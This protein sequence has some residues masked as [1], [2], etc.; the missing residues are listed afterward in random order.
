MMAFAGTQKTTMAILDE[1]FEGSFPPSGW[2]KF[3][4]FSLES[5]Q[6][7]SE[8]S[9]TGTYSAMVEV[10]YLYNQD[11]WL[12]TPALDLSGVSR[13][14]L[15]FYEDQNGWEGSS[16]TNSIEVSTTSNNS[17]S[18]FT[19]I[20]TMTPSDHTI[21]GFDGSVV[22]V[23]LSAYAGQ[24]TVYIA[25]HYHDPSSPNYQWY[26]DDVR[27]VTPSDHD[28]AAI[29]LDMDEHYAPNTTVT[30]QATV[31]NEGKNTESFDVEFGYY[32][33]YGEE[34]AISSTTVTDLAPGAETQI[35][36]SSYTFGQV[37]YKFYV[38]T[39]LSGDMDTAND[40]ATR[41]INS[42]PNQKEVVLSEEFTDTECT[43][44]PGAAEA[45][46]SLYQTYPDNVAIIAY[47]GGFS[48]N[49]PFN[50]EFALA[51]RHYYDVHSYPTC[52]FGG[53]RRKVG[54]AA[55]GSDWSGVYAGYEDAYLAERQEYTPLSLDIVWTENG[56]NTIN[57]TGT[58]TYD[59][60]I[61]IKNLYIRWA[62]CESHIA[63]NW[64]TSMD[65]LHFVER[66]MIPDSVG[67]KVWNNDYPA[68]V[69]TE[70]DNSISFDIPEGVVKENCELIAFVQNDDDK[71]ILVAAKVNLGDGPNAISG[72]GTLT[73]GQFALEQNYPNPF[74]PTTTIRYALPKAAH[75][76]LTLYDITGRKIATLIN[77]NKTAGH[78]EYSLNGSRLAS[79]IYFYSLDAGNFHATRKMI[80]LR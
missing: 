17:A 19:P 64:E 20:L 75:V 39:K 23:D 41:F 69:G 3:S 45:L 62:L 37:G 61:T 46:D 48:G 21:E 49:D 79:G 32:D 65:S 11:V 24:S 1:S 6:Q 66:L 54:G 40:V 15:Y 28:V 29:S 25:F 7:S 42:Y 4:S 56:S 8:K 53:D 14:T 18:A 52:I 77:E 58:V 9:R 59:A 47:H 35:S 63:Y 26:I 76:T 51:R 55:A 22:E 73:P 33:W 34:T 57:A 13:A 44:C 38:R 5:W 10:N 30:P 31:K 43:Y 50:N 68:G 80:L 70:V 67:T 74:N 2:T 36:F 16:G 72:K 71:E 12:V 60:E 27:V 78:Y